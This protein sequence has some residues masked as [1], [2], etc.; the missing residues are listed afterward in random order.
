MALTFCGSVE[1]P[2]DETTK[3]KKL[4]LSVKK[5]HF[6]RLAYKFSFLKVEQTC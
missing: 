6:L 5:E 1:T 3:P 2:L 4:T